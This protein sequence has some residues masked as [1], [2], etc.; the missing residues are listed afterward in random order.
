VNRQDAIDLEIDNYLP[1]V[2]YSVEE[3]LKILKGD[4]RKAQEKLI[5]GA[6]FEAQQTIIS[7]LVRNS[8]SD[9]F[10]TDLVKECYGYD[11]LEAITIINQ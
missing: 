7:I 4:D 8:M 9:R 11:L 5:R 2:T 6:T 3:I 10:F 1:D